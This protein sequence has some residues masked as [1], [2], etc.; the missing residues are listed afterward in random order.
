MVTKGQTMVLA[1]PGTSCDGLRCKV[2]KQSNAT[3]EVTVELL[4]YKKQPY[5]QP[6]WK[7]GDK[8]QVK[9]WELKALNAE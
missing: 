8:L 1:M 3:S 2:I 5:G 9:Q 4:E 6:G 7:A